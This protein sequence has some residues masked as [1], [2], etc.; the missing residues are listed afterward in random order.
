M[1]FVFILLSLLLL[2]VAVFALQNT[3][4]VTL[5]VLGWKRETSVAVLTLTAIATGA[6]IAGL[7]SLA[8]RLRRWQRS[9]TAMAAAPPVR[10]PFRP[11]EPPPPTGPPSR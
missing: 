6:V 2:A 10:D 5:K 9:R 3:D 4:P 11:P 1:Q 8:G 7:L